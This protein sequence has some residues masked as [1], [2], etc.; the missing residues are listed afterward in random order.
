MSVEAESHRIS[1]IR[2]DSS[3]EDS[4]MVEW[5]WEL[6]ADLGLNI[7]CRGNKAQRRMFGGSIPPCSRKGAGEAKMNFGSDLVLLL[8]EPLI[9]LSRN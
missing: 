7:S 3:V 5:H 4:K 9:D 2:L 8:I 6:E 1:V